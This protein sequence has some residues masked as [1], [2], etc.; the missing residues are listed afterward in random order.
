MNEDTIYEDKGYTIPSEIRDEDMYRHDAGQDLVVD[1]IEIDSIVVA[2]GESIIVDTVCGGGSD[3]MSSE[4][5]DK[6]I[7]MHIDGQ[8]QVVGGHHAHL[9][10]HHGGGGDQPDLRGGDGHQH[11]HE[12]GHTNMN[13]A[14]G[15]EVQGDVT[16]VGEEGQG[17]HGAGPGDRGSVVEV[18]RLSVDPLHHGGV[19]TPLPGTSTIPEKGVEL[20]WVIGGVYT[21]GGQVSHDQQQEREQVQ[22]GDGE[23]G[24]LLLNELT[25][26]EESISSGTILLPK[27]ISRPAAP[28][29]IRKKRGIIPSTDAVGNI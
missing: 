25:C 19:H 9:R 8:D 10:R 17:C 14:G 11:R 1:D 2:C 13:Q 3:I 20:G 7:F 26:K 23:D 4:T 21:A 22:G 24:K 28:M 27:A 16:Q 29:R 6:D 18:V 5:V 15:D 12:G